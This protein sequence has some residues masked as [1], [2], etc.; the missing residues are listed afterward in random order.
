MIEF[1]LTSIKVIQV[2]SG[3]MCR[4]LLY[5]AKREEIPLGYLI[6]DASHALAHQSYDV[7]Y[8]PGIKPFPEINSR[9][10]QINTDGF[11]IYYVGDNGTLQCTKSKYP[12]IDINNGPIGQNKLYKSVKQIL[13]TPIIYCMG[14]I[15]NNNFKGVNPNYYRDVQP[16][17]YKNYLFS[18]NG[19]FNTEYSKYTAKLAPY[20]NPEFLDGMKSINI[21]SKWLFGLLIS[22]LNESKDVVEISRGVERFL[23]IM[24]LIK[25]T[26]FNISLNILLSDLE[27]DIHLAL[28]YRT[29][30]QVPPAMYYN[31]L[32]PLGYFI[33]SEP[34][35][36][37]KGWHLMHNQLII[38]K[39]GICKVGENRRN[40]VFTSIQLDPVGVGLCTVLK[41]ESIN[42]IRTN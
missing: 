34:L 31:K 24:Y 25:D 28:R 16:Y 4:M 20:I 7:P 11:G 40:H 5:I 18:H 12:I 19:G 10:P 15:R 42:M 21:D 1:I 17:K 29:C 36:Y 27:N 23:N 9:N 37:E 32:H 38:I 6:F 41:K 22:Q 3:Q 26:G 13:G 2:A 39:P 14:F 30:K 33:S 35:D 8:L